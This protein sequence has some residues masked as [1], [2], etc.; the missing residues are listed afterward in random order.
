MSRDALWFSKVNSSPLAFAIKR[1]ETWSSRFWIEG[2]VLVASK[3]LFIF[4]LITIIS[5]FFLFYSVS[6]LISFNKFISNLVLVLFF[7]ALFPIAS[8]Q[9][10]GFIATIV[11]YIWPS[12]LFAYW[13]M[14]DNQRKS[15]TVASYKVIIST[16][17][18]ILSVFNEGLAIMLFLYLIIRLVIEKKEFLNIYRMI[19]LLVSFLSIL[20]VLF[21]PGNQKRGISEMTHWFP[22]FDHL[23]F[24]DKLLIQLDNIASNL[25]V[26]H[27]LMGI[28][29]LLLLARAVQKRQS[30]SIILSGLAIMLSKIS[31]SLISKPLDTIVKHSSGKEFNYNITSMLLAPSL[32][33]IIILGLVVFIIILLYGKSSKSLIAIT[34]LGTT[35]ATGMS[36]SLSPTLLASEDRPLLFLYFVIIFNCVV[37]LDDMIEFNKNK[38]KIVVKK[39]SE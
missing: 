14:I 15:E 2:A 16:F 1:Y 12:T 30:L 35:F 7:I 34:S 9:S 8:L 17:C 20:N 11:N 5:V 39:I 26:N 37:L 21:C 22:T 36:L 33:F 32:I 23:S 27:N 4:F 38:D 6:K 13:L 28:F 31:E 25:I 18:L 3:H 24:W 29:L 19:C 10:A